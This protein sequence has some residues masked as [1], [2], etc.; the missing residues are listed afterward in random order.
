MLHS[1]YGWWAG[2][3]G[4]AAAVL[5]V[6]CGGGSNSSPLEE[7][8]AEFEAIGGAIDGE[9]EA[10]YAEIPDD[11]FDEFMAD[12]ANLDLLKDLGGVLRRIIRDDLGGVTNLEPP[13]EVEDAHN[14]FVD[15]L[16]GLLVAFVAVD[17]VVSDAETA[18]EFNE[19]NEEVGGL[20]SLAYT[21]LFG[22]CLNLVHIAETNQIAN[23]ISCE[24]AR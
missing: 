20:I 18:A 9:I 11:G 23:E 12:D 10:A 17:R 24:R 14:D 2:G 21:R 5:T 3:R 15:A 22:V 13:G 1:G 19:F 16:A 8:Y 6:G 7:Y 4:T